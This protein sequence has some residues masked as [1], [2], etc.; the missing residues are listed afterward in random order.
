MRGIDI[1]RVVALHLCP[2]HGAPLRRTDIVRALVGHGLEGDV[3]AKN[4]A[5]RPNQV[6]L[7]DTA[8]LET[9][10]LAPGQLREQITLDFPNLHSLPEGTLLSIGQAVVQI[11]G[12]CVPCT[13]IGNLLGVSDPEALQCSLS[14]RRAVLEAVVQGESEG[15]VHLGDQLEPLEVGHEH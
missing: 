13:H 4:L 3:H 1:G 6:L 2:Q 14:R 9:L 8:T 15:W 10:A 5:D 11:T 12:P 7:I